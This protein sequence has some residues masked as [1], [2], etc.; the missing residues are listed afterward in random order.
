[1]TVP[2]ALAALLVL[3]GMLLAVA[4]VAGGR[5]PTAP[6]PRGAAAGP[7]PAA[8]DPPRVT[9]RGGRRPVERAALRV[10]HTWDARRAAAYRSASP[11]RLA[12]LYVA[13]STAGAAD[14]RLLQG[15]RARGYRVAGMHTQVL[16][17]D[18]LVAR[19]ARLWLRVSDRL[20]G[21]VAVRG[22]ERVPLPRDAV[23]TRVVAL[24]RAVGGR[25]QVVSVSDRPGAAPRAAPPR[26]GRRPSGARR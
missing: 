15:Y 23:S 18:V 24:R 11:P 8:T 2:R 13:G 25:W 16:A 5:S 1:M 20:A 7:G 3:A 19:P 10:L 21:A 22:R 4:T 26:V 14:V 17:V 9:V 6:R 12:G